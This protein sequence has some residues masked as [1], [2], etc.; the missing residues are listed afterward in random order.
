V[1]T[2]A[3]FLRVKWL[4]LEADHSGVS[5]SEVKNEWSHTIASPYAFVTHTRTA[6]PYLYR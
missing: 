4:G 6:V 1:G 3:F 5:S 2:R